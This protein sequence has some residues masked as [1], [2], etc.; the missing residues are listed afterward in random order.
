ME[1]ALSA[2]RICG[3]NGCL[4]GYDVER[5]VRDAPLMIAGEGTSEIQHNVVGRS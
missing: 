5:Y 3:G 4:T 1:I 2:V